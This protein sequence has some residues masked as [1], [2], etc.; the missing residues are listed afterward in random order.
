MHDLLCKRDSPFQV[1]RCSLNLQKKIFINHYMILIDKIVGRVKYW[2][3]RLLSYAGRLQ[4]IKSINFVIANYWMQCFPLPRFTLKKIDTICRS[5]LWNG[6]A[7]ISRK[8]HVAWKNICKPSKQGGLNII[9][10]DTWNRISMMKLLGNLNGK[11]DNLWV[12]WVHAY[13]FK[14]TIVIDVKI[15]FNS[16]S[17]IKTLMHQRDTI[18]WV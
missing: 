5:F 14:H 13:Y 10:L 4:L 15:Q 11:S 16:S 3:T 12:R 18:P 17:I 6:G 8:S 2:S 9:D 7:D 1:L